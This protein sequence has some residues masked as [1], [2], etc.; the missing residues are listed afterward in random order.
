MQMMMPGGGAPAPLSRRI[1]DKYDADSSGAIG[2][3]EF[4]AMVR[5]RGETPA[6]YR[7]AVINPM[8]AA[9]AIRY[10]SWAATLREEP[11]IFCTTRA[12]LGEPSI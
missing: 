11:W 6:Q 12:D 3:I 5:G 7:P 1:F 4:Q 9:R 8:R 10:A 2:G